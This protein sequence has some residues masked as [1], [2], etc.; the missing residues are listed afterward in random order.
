MEARDLYEII[1]LIGFVA[2]FAGTGVAG[3]L[4]GRFHESLAR[5]SESETRS[6]RRRSALS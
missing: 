2:L 3:Y 4:L 6:R 1:T 5:Q